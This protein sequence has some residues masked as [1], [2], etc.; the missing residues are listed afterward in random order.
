MSCC[1]RIAWPLLVVLAFAAGTVWH[2]AS[3][4]EDRS[5]RVQKWEYEFVP[6]YS[7]QSMKRMGD[8]GWELVTV[9]P[10]GQQQLFYFKRPK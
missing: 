7:E 3:A 8:D 5:R 9:L 6:G 4:Q 2:L 10:Q 1:Q